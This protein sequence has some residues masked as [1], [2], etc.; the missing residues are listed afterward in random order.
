MG[1]VEVLRPNAPRS[2]PPDPPM[3][4]GGRVSVQPGSSNEREARPEDVVV[5]HVTIDRA[6]ARSEEGKG[7]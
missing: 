1:T 5:E 4:W 2:K 7:A 3:T 6:E